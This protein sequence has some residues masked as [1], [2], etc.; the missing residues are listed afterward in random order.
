MSSDDL[1]KIKINS[2]QTFSQQQQQ[3]RRPHLSLIKMIIT[4]K[5]LGPLIVFNLA[6]QMITIDNK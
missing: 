2:F 5:N 1:S 3:G 4:P 6:T